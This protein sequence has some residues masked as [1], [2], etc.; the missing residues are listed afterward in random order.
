MNRTVGILCIGIISSGLGMGPANSLAERSDSA[1]AAELVTLLNAPDYKVREQATEALIQMGTASL[2]AIVAS[3]DSSSLETRLRSE[4]IFDAIQ[5]NEL[6]N[7]LALFLAGVGKPVTFEFPAWDNFA[8]IVGDSKAARELY[9][10]MLK[11]EKDLL[12]TFQ[13]RR[14]LLDNKLQIRMQTINKFLQSDRIPTIATILLMLTDENLQVDQ[15]YAS[16]IYNLCTNVALKEY[17]AASPEQQS[18]FRS[19]L[20]YYFH[21]QMPGNQYRELMLA[22]RYEM[23]RDAVKLA[24]QMLNSRNVRNY[25]QYTMWT[26]AEWGDASQVKMLEKHLENS[27]T[28]MHKSIRDPKTR[29]HTRYQIQMRDIAL[30]ALLIL[31]KQNPEKYG[32]KN[33]ESTKNSPNQLPTF[34]FESQT[35]RAEGLK[36][37]ED[38]RARQAKEADGVKT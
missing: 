27:Q 10:R 8:E 7:Q 31:T 22:I 32:M 15:R 25:I 38:Y 2:E 36:K 9:A 20:K 5:K 4:R 3:R 28:V 14:E 35:K 37:W 18:L 16:S 30:C 21:R 23:K 17:K 12:I 29:R 26:I 13:H 34:I 11:R 24:E 1:R 6:D 19:L 33:I